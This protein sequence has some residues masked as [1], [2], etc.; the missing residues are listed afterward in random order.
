MS[1]EAHEAA[2]DQY[3]EDVGAYEKR[4]RCKGCGDVEPRI[5]IPPDADP[6][7]GCS[8]CGSLEVEEIE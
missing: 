7:T 8:T 1:Y 2:E 6:H 5:V 3:L 4:L